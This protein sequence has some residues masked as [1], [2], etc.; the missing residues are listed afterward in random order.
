MPP[1]KDRAPAFVPLHPDEPDCLMGVRKDATASDFHDAAMMRQEA[2]LGV[3]EAV[4]GAPVHEMA[5]KSLQCFIGA[6]W[7]L[8]ADSL[9]LHKRAYELMSKSGKL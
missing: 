8:T 2:A 1:E 9:A 4:S 7:I 6:L 5:G 3:L